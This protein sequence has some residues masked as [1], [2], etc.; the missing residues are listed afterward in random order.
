MLA[1]WLRRT[2]KR[3]A[4]VDPVDQRREALLCDRV[5]R[6]RE[7]LLDIAWLLERMGDP[8]PRPVAELHKHLRDGC[9]SPLYNPDIH[10]SELRATLHYIRSALV[11]SEPSG[12]APVLPF[13]NQ[14]SSGG[15]R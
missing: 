12:R 7:Q 13:S 3:A 2:A 10:E 6:V 9:E 4:S 14:G 5:R 11:T 1:R 8:D 15:D